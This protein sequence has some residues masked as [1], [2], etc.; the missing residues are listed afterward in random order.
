MDAFL[1]QLLSGL[2]MGAIYA[3]IAVA[4]VMIYKATHH[5]N[6]AQGE[7]AMFATYMA[8]ILIQK[9]VPYWATFLI[10]MT[11]AFFIGAVIERVIMRWVHD[12]PVLTSV[13][14][15]I[16]LLILINALAGLFFEYQIK[17]FP[18]PFPDSALRS[19]FLSAHETG[20]IGVVLIVLVLVYLFFRYTKLGLAMRAS[21]ENPQSSKLVGV[22]VGQMLALGWGLAAALGSVAG[23]MAAPV[24]YLEP[25]F[26]AGILNYGF[27]SALLGGIDNPWG[28]PLGGFIVG[29]LV[30]LAGAY[31]VG[32]HLQQAVA[33]VIVITVLAFKPGGLF[34][35]TVVV[36]V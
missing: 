12:A 9:N 36:R 5:V 15:F 31:V 13:A 7:L 14:I 24:V 23:M 18:T 4:L 8:W 1:H 2:A 33:L 28:A 6:F 3:S 27:A 35:K 26:M 25:N 20:M 34:G 16:G 22:R 11:F 19:R 29:V 21:A 30:N 32:T 17:P 10:T